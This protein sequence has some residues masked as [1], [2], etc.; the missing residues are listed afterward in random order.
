MSYGLLNDPNDPRFATRGPKPLVVPTQAIAQ[1]KPTIWDRIRGGAERLMGIPDNAQGLLSQEDRTYARRQGLLTA[2]A[3]IAGADPSRGILSAVSQ[4]IS[5]GRGGA[6]SGLEQRDA[7]SQRR[8]GMERSSRLADIQAQYAGKDPAAYARALALGGFMDEAKKVAETVKALAPDEG[9]RLVQTDLGDRIQFSHPVTG[10][11]LKVI[12]KGNDPTNDK[13]AQ[14]QTELYGRFLQQTQTHLQV[15]EAWRRLHAAGDDAT[16]AGDVGL[17]TAYMKII[18]PTSSVKQGEFAEA[19]QTGSVPQVVVGLYNRVI[20]GQRLTPEQRKDFLRQADNLARTTRDSLKEITKEYG[21]RAT[22]LKVNP[23]SVSYDYFSGL[24][25]PDAAK[26]APTV[27]RV[28]QRPAGK[29]GALGKRGDV[30]D[31]HLGGS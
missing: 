9:Q 27:R 26:A 29:Q 22:E 5:E 7:L 18:D 30:L 12:P 13:T 25:I 31:P 16:P 8:A 14:H 24:T 3:G 20:T 10:E 2:G 6:M 1:R 23:Q 19:S 4:G 17:L 28:P 21:R 11:V 15:A